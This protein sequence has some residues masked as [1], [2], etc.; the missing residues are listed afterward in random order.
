[1]TKAQRVDVANECLRII[2][3]H[4]RRFFSED[5]DRPARVE[6][7]RVSSFELDTRGR[8]WYIDKW[9]GARIYVS[10]DPRW[11]DG[12][13]HTYTEGGTLLCLCRSL[14]NWILHQ[15]KTV[16][17][18]HFGPWPAWTCGGDVW[19]YGLDEMASV[20]RGIVELFNRPERDEA[21]A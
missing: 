9:R 20:R 18:G 8:L 2:A 13:G 6:N 11:R 1:M 17:F 5:A 16:P 3:S 21:S 15:E 7:P 19:G 10:H 12:W 4:G 14:R